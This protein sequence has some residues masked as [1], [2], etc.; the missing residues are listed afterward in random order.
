M[1]KIIV[2]ILLI[3]TNMYA[4]DI[5]QLYNPYAVEETPSKPDNTRL[6]LGGGIYFN[7]NV[8]FHSAGPVFSLIYVNEDTKVSHYESL[9][10]MVGGLT[11]IGKDYIDDISYKNSFSTYY[12]PYNGSTDTTHDTSDVN[13]SLVSSVLYT[14][15]WG[16]KVFTVDVGL[17]FDFIPYTT[18]DN[19]YYDD[20]LEING[21]F[22]IGGK[23]NLPTNKLNA[24]VSGGYY[25]SKMANS[26]VMGFLVNM[27]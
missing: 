16:V 14:I 20:Q 5:S 1:N 22:Y 9:S 12:N 25:K 18:N 4:W 11:D 26:I 8:M 2:I 7:Q 17:G 15:G 21:A 6:G 19:T 3:I 13:Y 27:F 10:Y 24:T 23:F